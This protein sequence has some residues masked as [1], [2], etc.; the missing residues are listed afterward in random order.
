MPARL[1]LE[2]HRVGIPH[3]HLSAD[4]AQREA[5]GVQRSGFTDVHSSRVSPQSQEIQC[6]ASDDP[7]LKESSGREGF[8]VLDK[9]YKTGHGATRYVQFGDE[10]ATLDAARKLAQFPNL[11][12]PIIV[13][14]AN[15]VGTAGKL[16]LTP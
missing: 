15:V 1:E 2:T 3:A 11:H 8:I 9:S 4:V 13:N 7:R 14:L 6:I 16:K 12:E 5:R 10:C